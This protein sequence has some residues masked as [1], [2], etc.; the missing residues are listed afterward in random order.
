MRLTV[1]FN[2]AQHE[3][4]K[5]IMKDDLQTNV[6]GYFA[7]LLAQELKAR[8]RPKAGR[9]RKG[10]EAEAEQEDEDYSTDLPK[11]IP[12]FGQNIGPKEYADKEEARRAFMPQG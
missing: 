12:Y 10:D 4:L 11:N 9:P 6:S 8:A 1:T 2:A 7:Y 5:K 3:A